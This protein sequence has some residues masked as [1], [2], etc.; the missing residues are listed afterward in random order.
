MRPEN[1]NLDCLAGGIVEAPQRRCRRIA[2]HGK[3]LRAL[4]TYIDISSNAEVDFSN[5]LLSEIQNGTSNHCQICLD[6]GD[7][8]YCVC[9]LCFW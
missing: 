4:H 5:I 2:S 7:H 6:I 9:V 8:L 3:W 1:E